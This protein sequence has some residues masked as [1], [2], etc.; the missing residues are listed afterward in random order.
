MMEFERNQIL[1]NIGTMTVAI[2]MR[3]LIEEYGREQFVYQIV[4]RKRIERMLKEEYCKV[5]ELFG[6]YDYV[7]IIKSAIKNQ[8][9]KSGLIESL[10]YHQIVD[11]HMLGAV[12][13]IWGDECIIIKDI[14]LNL[15]KERLDK[16]CV[17]LCDGVYIVEEMADLK[18]NVRLCMED[19]GLGI[20]YMY[21]DS[22]GEEVREDEMQE[23]E[24]YEGAWV[25]VTGGVIS[26]F[27]GSFDF[28]FKVQTTTQNDKL[29]KLI[30]FFIKSLVKIDGA[31]REV[32]IIVQE[33]CYEILFADKYNYIDIEEKCMQEVIN[34]I[35]AVII[36]E[37]L[38][39]ELKKEGYLL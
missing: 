11:T 1:E 25:E 24:D 27:C 14:F 17:E 30:H 12:L 36:G 37:I 15:N 29:K 21:Y 6:F 13:D 22:N 35:V 33:E 2:I 31:N 3:K 20:E 39:E 10:Y 16:N 19:F 9:K 8:F 18:D 7:E 5:K 34:S 28:L 38:V 26:E 4:N 32:I 23:C